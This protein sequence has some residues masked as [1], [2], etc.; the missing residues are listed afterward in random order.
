[1]RAE[2]IARKF[3]GLWAA[4]EGGSLISGLA[5]QFWLLQRPPNRRLTAL[6]L[7][8]QLC[9]CLAGRVTLR[10]APLPPPRPVGGNADEAPQGS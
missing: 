3:T 7:A 6:V 8:R 10:D 2:S 5:P 1:M 9:H 4:S